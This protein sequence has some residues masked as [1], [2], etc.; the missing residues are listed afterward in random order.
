MISVFVFAMISATVPV[1]TLLGSL[2]IR[3]MVAAHALRGIQ[4]TRRIEP[5]H[6]L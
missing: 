4:I 3:F 1:E 2:A 6:D 5:A